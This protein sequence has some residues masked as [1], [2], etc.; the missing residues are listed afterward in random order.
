MKKRNLLA[1]LV[2]LLA[3]TV[4]TNDA[5]AVYHAGTGRFMQRD[6]A[7]YVDGMSLYEYSGSGPA[8]HV[9]PYG[10]GRKTSIRVKRRNDHPETGDMGH[11][12]LEL[13]A[14]ESY[15]WYPDRRIP[16]GYWGLWV[17]TMGV[18]GDLNGQIAFGGNK[19]RDPHHGNTTDEEWDAEVVDDIRLLWSWWVIRPQFAYGE[20]AGKYCDECVTDEEI[21]GCIRAY[22]Q[23]M[24]DQDAGW[25]LFGYNC[26]SFQVGAMSG[27]C[28]SL[29]KPDGGG[30]W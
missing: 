22:A 20:K 2:G 8:G 19:T 28:L 18:P 3:V 11:W 6:P 17:S 24:V 15:G 30:G 14:D 1:I 21:K 26:H 16:V 25:A 7:G 13:G 23:T 10:T 12:W 5:W 29:G 4:I 9:D 27:C